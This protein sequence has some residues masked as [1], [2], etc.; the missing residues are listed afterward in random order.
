MPVFETFPNNYTEVH[1][2]LLAGRQVDANTDL[3]KRFNQVATRI[4][5]LGEDAGSRPKKKFLEHFS[6]LP[7]KS[8]VKA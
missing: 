6:V 8:S 4:L 3:G 1:Q 5:G 2:A 7:S